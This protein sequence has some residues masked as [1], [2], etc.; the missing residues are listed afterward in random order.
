MVYIHSPRL[1]FRLHDHFQT[2]AQWDT[3][4]SGLFSL[5]EKRFFGYVIPIV[6]LSYWDCCKSLL[7]FDRRLSWCNC[8]EVHDRWRWWLQLVWITSACRRRTFS[9]VLRRAIQRMDGSALESPSAASFP[10]RS[11]RWQEGSLRLQ[12]RSRRIRWR[13]QIRMFPART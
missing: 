11:R 5:A 10:T 8:G 1:H 12:Q 13:Y 3:S 6:E 9:T 4:K 2:L 7:F